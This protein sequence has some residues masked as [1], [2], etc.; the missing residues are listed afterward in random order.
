MALECET[1]PMSH[2]LSLAEH[3]LISELSTR[4][5]YAVDE[6]DL[7][8]L[9]DVFTAEAVLDTGRGIRRGVTEIITALARLE[10]YDAVFHHLGQR[11]IIAGTDAGSAMGDVYCVAHHLHTETDGSRINHVMYIRYRDRY[12][13]GPGGWRI[14]ERRLDTL[15]TESR[16]LDR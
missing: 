11:R 15:W 16:L 4:Y 8:E 2:S 13:N 6:G 14:S 9:V 5:A 10:R 3:H 7:G 12:E 1:Q